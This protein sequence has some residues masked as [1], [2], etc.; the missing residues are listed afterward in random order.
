MNHLR[1]MEQS[2]Q[3]E[4]IPLIPSTIQEL[5]EMLALCCYNRPSLPRQVLGSSASAMFNDAIFALMPP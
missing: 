5:E 1:N 2:Q 3:E 4:Q